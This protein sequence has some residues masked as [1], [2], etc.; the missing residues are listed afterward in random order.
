MTEKSAERKTMATSCVEKKGKRNYQIPTWQ[1][2][3]RRCQGGAKFA[4]CGPRKIP[5]GRV[6]EGGGK[7]GARPGAERDGTEVDRKDSEKAKTRI[8]PYKEKRPEG[9]GEKRGKA[10]WVSEGKSVMTGLGGGQLD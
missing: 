3:G 6:K 8:D 2:S 4:G 5:P 7:L 1:R 9:R 10:S